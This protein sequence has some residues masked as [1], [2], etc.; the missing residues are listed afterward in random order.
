MSWKLNGTYF[1]SC[2]CETACPCV[3]LSPPTQGECNVVLGW[4]IEHGHSDSVKLDGLNVAM[5]VHSPGKMH[6]V[7]WTIALYLD[8]K[9]S[10]EQTA[11][12][13]K[14]FG[15]QAGGHT[16]NLASH[17]EKILG[18][19]SADIQFEQKGKSFSLKIPN[20]ADVQIEA[21][22]GQGGGD[23][24]LAGHPLAISPGQQTTVARSTKLSYTDHG[25]T[26]SESAKSGLFAPFSYSA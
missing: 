10:A 25:L 5:A 4:H 19:T 1:E 2:N 16:A 3:F 9:A 20:V 24:V 18:V 8:S 22:K 17:V 23:V 13:T 14:I 12:L 7:K 26:W 6:E 15:G 11:E 21:V